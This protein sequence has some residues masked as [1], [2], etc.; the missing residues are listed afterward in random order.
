[1]PD[2]KVLRTK[3]EGVLANSKDSLWNVKHSL[4]IQA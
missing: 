3:V 1:M 4:T 2:Y